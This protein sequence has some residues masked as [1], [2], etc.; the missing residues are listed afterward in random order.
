[1]P[2]RPPVPDKILGHYGLQPGFHLPSTAGHSLDCVFGRVPI[3]PSP[4]SLGPALLETSLPRL[5]Q[6]SVVSG[7]CSGDAYLLRWQSYP[8]RLRF[9]RGSS[10]ALLAEHSRCRG[11]VRQNRRRRR[12]GCIPPRMAPSTRST[13]L[14]WRIG[15]ADPF[16]RLPSDTLI[17]EILWMNVRWELQGPKTNASEIVGSPGANPSAEL[18]F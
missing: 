15:K 9:K 5:R 7:S 1:M 10:R 18:R 4:P 16:Q 14:G 11:L 12:R 8:R 3:S 13:R 2:P 17:C 6:Q